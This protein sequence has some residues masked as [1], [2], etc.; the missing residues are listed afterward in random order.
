M[1]ARRVLVGV[2]LFGIV[3]VVGLALVDGA[4]RSSGGASSS[5]SSSLATGSQGLSGYAELL[6]RFAYTVRTARGSLSDQ[7][8][9]PRATLVVLDPELV[10]GADARAMRRFV[11][12]GGTLI[13]GG[14]NSTRWVR[15]AF[16]DAPSWSS[17][18]ATDLE[19]LEPRVL[20]GIS[21]VQA[22]GTG[23]WSGAHEP[24]LVADNVVVLDRIVRGTGT[25]FLLADA[26]PLQNRLLAHA[27]NAALG[28]ELAGGHSRPVVFAEGLHGAAGASGLAAVPD[29]WKIAL[30]G[31]ALAALL[32]ALAVGRR[33][34]PAEEEARELAPARRLYVD[35]MATALAR[36]RDPMRA[37]APLQEATRARLATRAGLAPDAD[38]D[39]LRAVARRAGWP[40]DEIASLFDPLDDDAGVL[41]A[42]RALARAEKG[43]W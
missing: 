38:D 34:G 2:A 37:L 4:T 1:T 5:P 19:S 6:H 15:A 39:D 13:A 3:V 25:A 43:E 23:S 12:A 14:T 28:L 42:G 22:A 8:V 32:T 21:S 17:N 16:A 26:S 29:R 41:A 18:G 10:D 30:V 9:D 24:L 36:T 11:D 31:A 40:D 7:T 20:P 33:L 35:A 27:D